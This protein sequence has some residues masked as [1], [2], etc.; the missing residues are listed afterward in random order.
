MK[1]AGKIGRK[2]KLGKKQVWQGVF[3]GIVFTKEGQ[4]GERKQF[5]PRLETITMFLGMI[6]YIFLV[7]NLI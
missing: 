5:F 4:N 1:E 3:L 2:Q 7:K 6:L